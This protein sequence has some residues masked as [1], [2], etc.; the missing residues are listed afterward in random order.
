MNTDK[1]KDLSCYL[2]SSV[3]ICGYKVLP[4]ASFSW[5]SS[6]VSWDP[7]P[8]T[9]V[10]SPLEELYAVQGP[11][12]MPNKLTP[13]W[14]VTSR[15]PTCIL[16]PARASWRYVPNSLSHQGNIVPK[17]EFWSDSSAE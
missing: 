5:A 2:C 17:F 11:V 9:Y 4:R 7:Y 10:D 15:R 1:K 16:S 14:I 13:C 6:F 3:S 12:N 8:W